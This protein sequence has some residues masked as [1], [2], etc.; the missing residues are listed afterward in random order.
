ML[1]TLFST[2]LRAVL[3]ATLVIWGISPLTSFGLALRVVLVAK[4]V[5]S[6]IWSSIFFSEL[7][8]HLF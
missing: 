5:I 6:V 8:K 3:V 1:G 7:F 2:S 4:L